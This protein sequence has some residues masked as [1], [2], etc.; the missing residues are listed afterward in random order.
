[1]GVQVPPLAPRRRPTGR[2]PASLRPT[3]EAT[4]GWLIGILIGLFE[5]IAGEDRTWWP[6]LIGA[7]AFTAAVLIA[8]IVTA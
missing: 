1:M 5:A 3:P 8:W 4:I 6:F 2:R 7:V